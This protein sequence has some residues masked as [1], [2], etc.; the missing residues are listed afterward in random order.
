MEIAARRPRVGR[1][2]FRA[3]P[4]G[5][6]SL[7]DPPDRRAVSREHLPH[8]LNQRRRLVDLASRNRL[9]AVD[10]LREFVDAAGLMVNL[11]DVFRRAATYVD[12]VL[13]GANQPAR[14]AADDVR[15]RHQP[16]DRQRPSA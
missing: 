15:A 12:N 11:A 16:Q 6:T 9:P 5:A 2:R 4:G 14:R 13:K 10:E 1:P 7:E 3:R 8:H